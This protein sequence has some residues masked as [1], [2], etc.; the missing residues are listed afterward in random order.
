MRFHIGNLRIRLI[1]LVLL[2]VLPL[3]GLSFYTA[4]EQRQLDIAD[5][6]KSVL[7]FAE[8][9][10]RDEAQLLDGTRQ[11]L[12]SVAHYLERQ[13][14]DPA[15]CSRYLSELL[16]H[17]RRYKNL[18]AVNAQGNFHSSALAYETSLNAS[19]RAWFKRAME[20]KTFA[21]GDYQ[22]GRITG[23][24]V[25]VLAYPIIS[26][27]GRFLGVAFAALDIQWLNQFKSGIERGLVSGST[28]SQIDERGVVLAHH[29]DPDTW[30]GRSLA[31]TLLFDAVRSNENGIIEAEGPDG[32]RRLYAFSRIF[33]SFKNRNVYMLVGIPEDTLYVEANRLLIH[34]LVLLTIVTFLAILAAWFGSDVFV[35]RQVRAMLGTA[36][37]LANGDLSA[38]TGLPPRNRELNELARAFDGMAT[39][40]ESREKQRQQ[41]EGELRDS[42]EQL[43]NLSSHL[44]SVREEERTRLA[45]EIHDELG[46]ELTALKMDLSW[47][48][49]RLEPEQQQLSQKVGSM[50]NLVDETI[51]T[52]QRLS[53]ELRPGLLDDLGLAA[54]IEWQTEEF[55]KRTGMACDVRLDLGE[56]TLSH[57]Q[58]TAIFRIYQETLTNVIRHAR[59][60]RVSILL[61]TQDNRLVLEVTDNG[62]GITEEEAGGAKAFGLIGMRERVLALKGELAI[63]GRPG[64]GTTVTVTI[65]LIT[66][67][68]AL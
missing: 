67:E 19:D 17:Y 37:R 26:S 32:Q 60:T 38:R 56:T 24:P 2:A 41:A 11:L 42:H 13:W 21:I 15:E 65:P 10:A 53:G 40:L 52:V 9:A 66:P 39:A 20:T 68:N 58:D 48:S 7:I 16:D 30:V 43:R 27:D 8:F 44:E 49:K 22:I 33:S 5:I 57:N 46:Q 35:L 25:I 6:E 62:R 34:N 31:S 3:A 23:S 63:H 18:G 61:Q 64:Q 1:L 14:S 47:V 45:R 29:P 12:A 4:S 50:D 51:R 54:A 28:I 36:T 55:Q 59:A